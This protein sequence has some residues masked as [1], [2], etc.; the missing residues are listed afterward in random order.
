[1]KENKEVL[2]EIKTEALQVLSEKLAKLLNNC[3]LNNELMK[4]LRKVIMP[5]AVLSITALCSIIHGIA[6]DYLLSLIL[7]II[8]SVVNTP[9]VANATI[10]YKRCK[11]DNLQTKVLLNSTEKDITLVLEELAR[12]K[13]ND[14]VIL[15]ECLNEV[16]EIDGN[17]NTKNRVRVRKR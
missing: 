7:G 2:I 4:K 6:N 17:I 5:T 13:T 1:M 9:V 12:L 10:V 15:D 14:E 11:K 3:Y 16:S 8:V